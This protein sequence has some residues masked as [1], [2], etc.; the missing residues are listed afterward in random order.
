MFGA[1]QPK[2]T[3]SDDE[4][5]GNSLRVDH[6]WK[7]MKV[8]IYE[9]QLIMDYRIRFEREICP[10][11]AKLRKVQDERQTL[12]RRL[13]MTKDWNE[14]LRAELVKHGMDVPNVGYKPEYH[15]L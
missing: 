3:E 15:T 10:L 12:A 7:P 5:F 1:A 11:V 9:Q 8:N 4:D 14:M 6:Q 13:L 2:L